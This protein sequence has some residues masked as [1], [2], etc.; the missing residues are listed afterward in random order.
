VALEDW[1]HS[2][3]GAEYACVVD[4]ECS[5]IGPMAAA[6]GDPGNAMPL[7]RLERP[8][9]VD[10]AYVGSCTGGKREDIEQAHEVVRWA[11]DHRVMLPLQVQLFIQMGSEDVRRHAEEQGWIGAFEEAGARVISPGCGACIHAGPGISTR[12][13]QVTV[14]TFNRNFPGRSGP[15]PVWLASPATV[16]A[17]AFFGR[18]CSFEKLR[19]VAGA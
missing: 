7:D 12:A 13:G 14:G 16:A 11:L 15:G 4:V 9:P 19:T 3:P 2:D 1:M 8:V 6:P 17:S 10:I 5:A 18:M